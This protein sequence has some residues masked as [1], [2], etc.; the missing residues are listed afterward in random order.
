MHET[1]I[2]PSL[3]LA[4]ILFWACWKKSDTRLCFQLLPLSLSAGQGPCV[5]QSLHNQPGDPVF[6]SPLSLTW[7]PNPIASCGLLSYSLGLG[8]HLEDHPHLTIYLVHLT[9]YF[10]THLINHSRQ[11]R[12][13]FSENLHD[14][15]M[16]YI[17]N[18]LTSLL[19][20]QWPHLFV[21][22]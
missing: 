8:M 2:L 21:F 5:G 13:S 9:I 17:S 4:C 7:V 20:L 18:S 11:S 15:S 3:P 14:S 19:E 1:D 6:T 16:D 10:F 12:C 22:D